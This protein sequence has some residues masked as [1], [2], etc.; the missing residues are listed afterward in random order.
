MVDFE[1]GRCTM[2]SYPRGLRMSRIRVLLRFPT[3]PSSESSSVPCS[4][5]CADDDLQSECP[6]SKDDGGAAH[7]I[8]HVQIV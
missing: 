3:V 4:S 1:V 7:R 5:R 8:P 6:T 2:K